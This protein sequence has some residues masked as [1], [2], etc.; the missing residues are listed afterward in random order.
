E[1]VERAVDRVAQI[2]ERRTAIRAGLQASVDRLAELA[3]QVGARAAQWAHAGPD[4]P[5]R[6]R[7]SGAAV[8]ILAAPAL[9]EHQRQRVDVC[10]GPAGATPARLGAHVG[11]GPAG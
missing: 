4:R 9:I 2:L 1:A 7:R 11:G 10:P 8:G 5:R 6:R 3:R